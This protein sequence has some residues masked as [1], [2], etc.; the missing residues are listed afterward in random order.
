[1][2]N[3]ESYGI[4]FELGTNKFM[5]KMQQLKNAI[6]SFGRD[7][8][9]QAKIKGLEQDFEVASQKA[10]VLYNKFKSLKNELNSMP[11]WK[12]NTSEYKKLIDNVNKAEIAYKQAGVQ[13]DKLLGKIQAIEKEPNKMGGNFSKMQNKMSKGFDKVGNKVRRFALA[14]FSIRS[15]YALASRASQAYL[16][17]DTA[18]AEKLQSAWA[19]LG[20]MLAPVIETI[21]SM[22]IKAVSYINV[23][24]KALTGVDYIAKAS[25]KSMS[26]LNKTA[27]D[28][29]KTLAG[30]D[31]ITNLASSNG[32]TANN[33]FASFNDVDLDPKWVSKLQESAKW[34]KENWDWIEAVGIALGVTFGA[35]AIGNWLGNIG[36]LIG[37]GGAS[38]SGLLGL[39]YVLAILATTYLV[40]LA[41]KGVDEVKKSLDEVNAKV[42][43]NTTISE[44]NLQTQKKQ[45]DEWIEQGKQGKLSTEQIKART[46]AVSKDSEVNASNV[47]ELIK[48]REELPKVGIQALLCKKQRDELTKQIQ[49]ETAKTG[50][51]IDEMWKWHEQGVLNEEQTKKLAEQIAYQGGVLRDNGQDV[52]DL[53]AKY[54]ELTG[55]DWHLSLNATLNDKTQDGLSG[56]VGRIK[57]SFKKLWGGAADTFKS[58]FG[59]ADGGFPSQGEFFLA[60]ESGPELVGKIGNSSAV[61]NNSQIVDAVAKGVAE[62]VSSVMGGEKQPII[63]N[64]GGKTLYQ[65]TVDYINQ[66]S[67]VMGR[68]VIK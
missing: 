62:A 66:Q 57:N 59:Y 61:A 8:K 52:S 42:V 10:D 17:Q 43:E 40:V 11:T 23:F 2:K 22:V 33:P 46:N 12:S 65:D 38:G 63:V 1:M 67:R 45:S 39:Q 14:L 21:S 51:N 19:G 68:S 13:S 64:V 9:Q 3:N 26:K 5:A 37:V 41:I 44:K 49:L 55:Q 32:S 50:L 29:T 7:A 53:R 30:F 25:S 6:T 35:L 16:S 15:I 54:K 31:E 60:R 36:K 28:T 56:L 4:E 18:L 27:K 20:A 48:Q 24:I 47:L 58:I 34:L